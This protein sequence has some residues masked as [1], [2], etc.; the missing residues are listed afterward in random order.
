M[1]GTAFASAFADAAFAGGD[2]VLM[3][4]IG[5]LGLKIVN[6]LPKTVDSAARAGTR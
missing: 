2:K 5:R 1:A 3:Q 6:N 4:V